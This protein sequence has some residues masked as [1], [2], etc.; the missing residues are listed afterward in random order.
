MGN[1]KKIVD[2]LLQLQDRFYKEAE[3][4]Y[5]EG[6]GRVSMLKVVGIDGETLKLKCDGQRIVYA[7]GNEEPV[8]VLKCTM[9]CFLDVVSGDLSLREAITKGNFV[10][11]T[12]SDGNIN[13]IEC[14]KWAKS[15]RAMSA[16][17]A[18]VVQ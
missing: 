18:K 15:F 17:V 2:K 16:I 13:L 11:E 6:K 7:E 9:D 14:E 10:I 4:F 3:E 5:Q 12:A 8:H 1:V